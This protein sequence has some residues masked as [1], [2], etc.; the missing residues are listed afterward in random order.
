MYTSRQGTGSLQCVLELRCT[1][2]PRSV[3][4][5]WRCHIAFKVRHWIYAGEYSITTTCK[6]FHRKKA[7]L[8]HFPTSQAVFIYMV[9]PRDSPHWPPLPQHRLTKSIFERH[10][11]LV[12]AVTQGDPMPSLPRQCSGDISVQDI[13]GRIM[14]HH[15][16]KPHNQSHLSK[17]LNPGRQWS[18]LCI[19]HLG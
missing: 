2:L 6:P 1:L 4:C 13:H 16:S 19:A 7:V 10:F 12:G 8:K 5:V 11:H 14:K 3:C 9:I 18:G 15:L 17:V